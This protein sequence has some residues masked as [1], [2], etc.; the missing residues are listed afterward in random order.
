M[1]AILLDFTQPEAFASRSFGTHIASSCSTYGRQVNKSVQNG[2]GHYFRKQFG[3]DLQM[4]QI[5]KRAGRISACPRCA[6][7]FRSD[8][9]TKVS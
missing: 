4:S 9:F 7:E 1:G 6:Q 5:Q 8:Y 3:L 2:T